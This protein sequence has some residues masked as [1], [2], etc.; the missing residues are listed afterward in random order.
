MKNES[1]VIQ[2]DDV[3]IGKNLKKLRRSKG[4]KQ[5]DV[6]ARL[7]LLGIEISTYSYSRIENGKQNPTVSL[8]KGLTEIYGCDYNKFF[9]ESTRNE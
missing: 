8:L 5:K 3:D 6:I 9:G 4:L 1:R 7:Q 2:I